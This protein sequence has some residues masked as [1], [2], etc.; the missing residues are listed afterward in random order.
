MH[1]L[2]IEI[3]SRAHKNYAYIM[4]DRIAPPIAILPVRIFEFVRGVIGVYIH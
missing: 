3:Q 4:F 2:Y 1:D